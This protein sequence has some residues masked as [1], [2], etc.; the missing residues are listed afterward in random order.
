MLRS[1]RW[2][3]VAV[4]CWLIMLAGCASQGK[5]GQGR[6]IAF[7]AAART[8]TVVEDSNP[9]PGN[10]RYEVL[11]PTSLTLPEDP[12]SVGPI[13]LA[14]KILHMDFQAHELVIFDERSNTLATIR[15]DPV[16]QEEGVYKNDLRVAG[17]HFPVVDRQAR[18]ITLYSPQHRILMTFSV[19][20]EYLALPEDTWAIGDEVRY[21]YKVEGQVLR[22]MNVTQTDIS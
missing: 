5:V 20:D 22:I 14:G 8:V 15:Y 3:W 7:D 1:Y 4:C 12:G 19:P 6:V 9:A 18:T 2:G 21:Y 17:K 11:P 10:P 13:P 16:R